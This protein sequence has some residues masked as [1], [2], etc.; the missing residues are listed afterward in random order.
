MKVRIIPIAKI[1]TEAQN[2]RAIQEDE[3]IIELATSIA[4]QGL[5]QPIG[6]QE[7]DDGFYQLL[8]GRRRF[9]AHRRLERETIAAHVYDIG[10][11]PVKAVALVENLQREPMALREEVEA[12]RYLHEDEKRSTDQISVALSKGRSWVLQRMMV[13]NLPDDLRLPLLE[14][15]IKLGAAE[16]IARLPD[17]AT[18]N[19][20]VNQAIN[21]RMTVRQVGELVAHH[22]NNPAIS[23]AGAWGE[24]VYRGEVDIPKVFQVCESCGASRE[25]KEFRL[26]RV[27][28][29]GCRPEPDSG[30]ATEADPAGAGHSD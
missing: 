29:N 16:H 15:E 1:R 21:G 20:C 3:G 27:C 8:W 19:L 30:G 7:L 13:P 10:E 28:G 18:R 23:E 11:D 26:V 5:L 6:V 22:L 4:R 2:L 9:L 24:K 12:V 14:G 17:E 25:T